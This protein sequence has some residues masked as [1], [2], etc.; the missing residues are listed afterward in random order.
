MQLNHFL[1]SRRCSDLRYCSLVIFKLAVR[2]GS[3]SVRNVHF[4]Y[5]VFLFQPTDL[6][7]VFANALNGAFSVSVRH[8]VSRMR[9]LWYPSNKKE[10]VRLAPVGVI[11]SWSK[12]A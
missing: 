3:V 11:Y 1:D 12:T 2:V 9:V 5:N 4:L 8:L 7:A 10:F 6:V